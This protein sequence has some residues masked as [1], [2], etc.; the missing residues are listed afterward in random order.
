[1]DPITLQPVDEI[2]L[3]VLMDNTLDALLTDDEHTTRTGFEPATTPAAR[4]ETRRT[5]VGPL[6]EHGFSALVTVRGDR[7]TTMLFDAGLPPAGTTTNADCLG[8]ALD[9]LQGVIL[10]HATSTTREA[11]AAWPTDSAAAECPWSSTLTPG[12]D[13]ASTARTTPSTCPPSARRHSPR[14]D[15]RASNA[16]S[17]PSS[18]TTAC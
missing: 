8:T 6:A 17:P 5:A 14:K 16:D 12:H 2:R 18:S 13:D 11:S 10:S 9:N 15:S 1:M 3:T 7:E 4:F